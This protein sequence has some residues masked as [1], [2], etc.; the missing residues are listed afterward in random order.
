MAGVKPNYNAALDCEDF[1]NPDPSSIIQLASVKA[2]ERPVR[3]LDVLAKLDCRP[4]NLRK[5]GVIVIGGARK[6][7]EADY[8][9]ILSASRA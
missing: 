3:L 8:R 9:R 4:K 6:I 2:L 5:W 7:S 1:L